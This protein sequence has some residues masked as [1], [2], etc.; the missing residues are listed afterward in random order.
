MNPDFEEGDRV[1]ID[2]GRRGRV[3]TYRG[4]IYDLR[5]RDSIFVRLDGSAGPFDLDSFDY[6]RLHYLDPIEL[7]AELD[8]AD[9]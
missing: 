8:D 7:L 4:S 6:R 1:V 3:V 9:S 5:I 2:T